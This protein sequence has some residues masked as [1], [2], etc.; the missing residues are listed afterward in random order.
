MK[1][2]PLLQTVLLALGLAVAGLPV[3]LLTRP[4]GRAAPVVS[5]APVAGDREAELSVTATSPAELT[6]A[7]SGTAIWHSGAPA[8]AF[9]GT[10]RLPEEP[11]DLVATVAWTDSVATQAVRIRIMRD[12]ETL[13]DSSLWGSGKTTEVVAVTAP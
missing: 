8:T 6:L 7:L 12:G 10:L 3:W 5:V 2:S 1:G 11:V 9:S 13:A 4:H